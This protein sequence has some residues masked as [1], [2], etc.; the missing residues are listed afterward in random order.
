MP[1][2]SQGHAVDHIRVEEAHEDDRML[3]GGGVDVL[4]GGQAAGRLGA[5]EV[6]LVP[7]LADDPWPGAVSFAR[8]RTSSVISGWRGAFVQADAGQL[9]A[10]LHQ[11]VVVSKMPGSTSCGAGRRSGWRVRPAAAGSRRRP[12]QQSD[13]L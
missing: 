8:S 2:R 1:A 7:A 13:R 5:G 6:V 12:R 11:V 3:V 9:D 10:H 4:A